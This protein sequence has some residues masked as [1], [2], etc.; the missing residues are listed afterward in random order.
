MQLCDA[1]DI[2][3]L[4]LSDTPGQHGRA[5]GREDR[6][7]PALL[8]AVHDRRQPDRAAA[9]ASSCARPTAW[10][11][12][13][14]PAAASTETFFAVS[15]PTGEFGGM[16]LEGSVKLGYRNELRP[17]PTRAQRRAA[18]TRWSP[19]AYEPGKALNRATTFQRRR[20]HRPGRHPALDSAGH[21]RRPR[22]GAAPGQAAPQHRRLVASRARSG[23]V[24]H[25]R[26]AGLGGQDP[27]GVVDELDQQLAGLARVDDVLG[28]GLGGPE[29]GGQ[30]VQLA[31]RSR[32]CLAAGSAA[33]SISR[34]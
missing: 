6:A 3:I 23:V 15:W 25:A 2:P 14:W 31:P 30:G 4:S 19:H 32:R 22:P 8:A 34:R 5:G 16:G 26:H 1:F 28:G 27:L 20:R 17:S 7:G 10:A 24:G 29:R 33:A 12:S 9:S 21:G 13:P 11:P 18:S